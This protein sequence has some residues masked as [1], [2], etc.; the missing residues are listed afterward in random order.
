[1][2]TP[3]SNDAATP[4]LV[5]EIRGR[6]QK[7]SLGPWVKQDAFEDQY[8]WDIGAADGTI[9]ASVWDFT[10]SNASFIEHART[11]IPYL[12]DLV[13]SLQGE[14]ARLR[15]EVEYLQP[16][17]EEFRSEHE[18][19][20]A[21]VARLTTEN[22]GIWELAARLVCGYCN[23]HFTSWEREAR[24]GAPCSGNWIHR[25]KGDASRSVL[26]AA[27]SIYNKIDFDRARAAK[28]EEGNQG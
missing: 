11:D 15:R 19:L 18:T 12:L 26:C 20:R 24:R 10:V 27:T 8:D 2:T 28:V 13:T 4:E 5:K 3:N 23:G 14:S 1:M 17:L 25:E 9:V 22:A 16:M 6:L 21:E 7:A